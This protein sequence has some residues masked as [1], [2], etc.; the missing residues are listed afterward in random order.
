MEKK[1]SGTFA[2]SFRWFQ[3]ALLLVSCGETDGFN[4]GNRWFHAMKPMVS[5]NETFLKLLASS[6]SLA[7]KRLIR[8]NV[9]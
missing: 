7:L 6:F 3:L 8:Y 5:S 9:A 1:G 4:V 2:V